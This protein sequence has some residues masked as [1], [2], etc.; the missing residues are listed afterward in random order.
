V[1][2]LFPSLTLFFDAFFSLFI[3]PLMMR[4]EI[5]Y[6]V[7]ATPKSNF[8]WTAGARE[9]KRRVRETTAPRFSNLLCHLEI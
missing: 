6:L 1:R 5:Y 4:S 2:V 7:P 8:G 9:K 3:L